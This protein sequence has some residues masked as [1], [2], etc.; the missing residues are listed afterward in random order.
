MNKKNNFVYEKLLRDTNIK[1]V[2]S[3]FQSYYPG[4][5]IE[6]G[7]P[8]RYNDPTIW[9]FQS[10]LACDRMF[11]MIFQSFDMK[12]ALKLLNE[13]ISRI[14]RKNPQ[15]RDMLQKMETDMVFDLLRLTG[16]RSNDD[17]AILKM[18]NLCGSSYRTA[19]H[20][21]LMMFMYGKTRENLCYTCKHASP[22][23]EGWLECAAITRK[24]QTQEWSSMMDLL[25]PSSKRLKMD[26]KTGDMYTNF[27]IRSVKECDCYKQRFTPKTVLLNILS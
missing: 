21:K 15:A 6:I 17:Y 8:I 10:E 27:C 14:K 20:E 24:I 3:D 16:Y 11:C 22:T 12:N 2:K 19:V 23:D 1:I 18:K 13:E 9:A 4:I 5:V 26:L 25:G 7:G